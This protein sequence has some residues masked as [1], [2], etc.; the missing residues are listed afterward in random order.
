MRPTKVASAQKTVSH[1][2]EGR[3]LTSGKNALKMWTV[4]PWSY[5]AF[6]SSSSPKTSSSSLHAAAGQ[7]R[8]GAGPSD[9]ALVV[10]ARAGE[11][12]AQEA[13]FRRH[14][15]RLNGL[16][17]RVMGGRDADDIDDLV[18][19]SFIAAF[20]TL[21]RLENADAFATWIRSILVRQAHK[22]IRHRR[23]LSRLGLRSSTPIDPNDLISPNAPPE[24]AAELRAIYGVLES[25][26][27]D[28][29]VPLV[30]HRVE[31][32]MLDEVATTMDISLA[33]VKRRIAAAAQILRAFVGDE[34]KGGGRQ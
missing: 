22:K 12:W 20:T 18:Q 27:A 32:L 1:C 23:L 33:T 15:P 29:R 28:L 13:L 17:Y 10:S 19:D 6:V 31:G 30:L 21:G 25:M 34:E 3:V 11:A 5:A 4:M 14:A 7:T 16:A 26:S 8:S 9:A 2:V 24:K